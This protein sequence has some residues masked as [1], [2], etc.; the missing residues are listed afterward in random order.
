MSGLTADRRAE[1]REYVSMNT[2]DLSRTIT[3]GDLA[4]LLAAADEADRLLAR[5]ARLEAAANAYLDVDGS[6]MS[7][8]GCYHAL[9]ITDARDKLEAA[10]AGDES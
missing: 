4:Y 2:G 10:L 6:R 5:V 8:G 3:L 9:R 7:S 1:L